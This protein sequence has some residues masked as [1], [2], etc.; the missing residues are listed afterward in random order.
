MSIN[1]RKKNIIFYFD[2]LRSQVMFLV[3]QELQLLGHN[4]KFCTTDLNWAKELDVQIENIN[5]CLTNN[6]DI[7]SDRDFI[8]TDIFVTDDFKIRYCPDGAIGICIPHSLVEKPEVFFPKF[9]NWQNFYLSADFVLLANRINMDEIDPAKFS[10]LFCQSYPKEFTQYRK[11][12][13]YVV[14]TGYAKLDLLKGSLAKRKEVKNALLFAPTSKFLTHFTLEK[15]KNICLHLLR[16]FPDKEIIYRPFPS[17]N[18]R[19]DA[20]NIIE[21]LSEYCN[22]TYDDSHSILDAQLRT[23]LMI[24]DLSS[25]ALSFSFSTFTPHIQL[26]EQSQ[27]KTTE[28]LLEGDA[29][30]EL[31]RIEELKNVVSLCLDKSSYWKN[32][33]ARTQ[34]KFL[35]HPEKSLE[36]LSKQIDLIS[37]GKIGK[38]WMKWSRDMEKVEIKSEDDFLQHVKNFPHLWNPWIIRGLVINYLRRKF[39]HSHESLINKI[40]FLITS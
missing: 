5:I 16:S 23:E 6:R 15:T 12:N 35:Y 32:K 22:F 27:M 29:W 9:D 21:E 2:G 18:E 30:Y 33:I 24:T 10:N 13:L 36:H 25:G 11:P 1:F 14:P 31:S 28:F 38:D 39:P 4:I 17:D 37:Q 3:A 40:N 8:D 19:L 26:V 20:L 7:S 34:F